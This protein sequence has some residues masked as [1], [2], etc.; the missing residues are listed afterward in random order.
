MLHKGVTAQAFAIE[1]DARLHDDRADEVREFLGRCDERCLTILGWLKQSES[2]WARDSERWLAFARLTVPRGH[3][4]KGPEDSAWQVTAQVAA[5]VRALAQQWLAQ[6]RSAGKADEGRRLVLDDLLPWLVYDGMP[7]E[8]VSATL[9][10]ALALSEG[11]YN[12]HDVLRSMYRGDAPWTRDSGRWLAF[13]RLMVP[14]GHVPGAPGDRRVTAEVAAE[15]RALAEQWL[16]HCR[17]TGT[18]DQGA[19]LV[20]KDLLPWLSYDGMP[21]EQVTATLDWALALCQEAGFLHD[22]DT[23]GDWS[24]WRRQPDWSALIA[25]LN[26]ADLQRYAAAGGR[27]FDDILERFIRTRQKQDWSGWQAFFAQHPLLFDKVFDRAGLRDGALIGQ[28]WP[29]AS[30]QRREELAW[31][32]MD[33]VGTGRGKELVQARQLFDRFAHEDAGPFAAALRDHGHYA[34]RPL[35]QHI[36]DH[37]PAALQPLL[38]PAMAQQ[39]QRNDRESMRRLQPL[40]RTQVMRSPGDLAG[41]AVKDLVHLLPTLDAA[42]LQAALPTLTSI[43]AGSSAKGLRTAVAALAAQLQPDWLVQAGWLE[44]PN[45][46]LLLACRDVLLVHPDPGA[47]PLLA[48]LLAGAK[49]DAASASSVRQRLQQ[50]G[51]SGQA[52][53]LP[54]DSGPVAAGSS[55]PVSEAASGSADASLDAQVAAV[56]RLSA[57]IKPFDTPE[58]LALCAPLSEHE[59]RV[60]LHVTATAEGD[61]PPLATE[62]MARMAPD[63]RAGLALALVQQWIAAD[64]EPKQRWVLRLL[65]GHADN[66]AVDALAAAVRAWNR[67]HTPRAVVALEALAGVDSLYALLRA[68]EVSESRALKERLQR[69]ALDALR[70]AAR[71]RQ[72]DLSELYDELTP[73]FGLGQGLTLTVGPQAYRVELQGDLSLRVVNGQGKASKSIPAVR[74]EALKP[75]WEAATARLKTLATSLKTVVKQQGPRMLAA[76]V[77]GKRWPLERWQR[78]FVQHPLL[79]IVGR[80]L[81]WRAEGAPDLARTSFRLAEDLSLVDVEDAAVALP[82]G[83]SISLWHPATALPGEVDAWRAYFADYELEALVDQLGACADLPAPG[84]FKD[85]LLLPPAPLTLAQESLGSLLKKF[86]YRPGPVGDGPSI[87]EHVWQLPELQLRIELS[88][89]HFPPYLDLGLPVDVESIRVYGMDWNS[90][91]AAQLPKPLLATLQGHWRALAA[92]AKGND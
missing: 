21:Y 23:D 19:S 12:C 4:L 15:V 24:R 59:A 61:L 64:G 36:C 83:C 90:R 34:G 10:W 32:L 5:E 58:L 48:Q 77:S 91:S 26:D 81:I 35:F 63:G 6:C 37:G 42:S 8:E 49:L 52:Q 79:R 69:V 31:A 60:L 53:V 45:K 25:A 28:R 72:M 55:T 16:A 67:T 46:N 71:R 89:G 40:I 78:L 14:R 74:D 30:A 82:A 80:S 7:D 65:P 41:M 92:K 13:A 51:L 70:A 11:E 9:D 84:Q 62:L 39:C 87:N 75:E 76:L 56:K 54:Q 20:L 27:L 85:G 68:Q 17:S 2:P 43:I 88:H 86:G 18:L 66:R 33:Q 38:L 1:L 22:A 29:G 47:G 50:L 3:A 57:A 73:D 44:Q